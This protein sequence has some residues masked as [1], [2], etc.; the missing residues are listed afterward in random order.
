VC[1]Y[2]FSATGVNDTNSPR[3]PSGQCSERAVA[4]LADS[5]RRARQGSLYSNVTAVVISTALRRRVWEY[6]R[7]LAFHRPRLGRPLLF[8]ANVAQTIP[9]L[10][11]LGFLLRFPSSAG[12]GTYRTGHL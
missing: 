1:R 3:Q 7:I 12:S 8:L 9:S 2:R 10:A 11:L 5:H 4:F 6:R